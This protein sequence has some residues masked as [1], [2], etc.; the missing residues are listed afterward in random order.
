MADITTFEKLEEYLINSEPAKRQET[1]VILAASKDRISS[2]FKDVGKFVTYDDGKKPEAFR[3]NGEKLSQEETVDLMS[4]R[5]TFKDLAAL[6]ASITPNGGDFS[7]TNDDPGR[8]GLKITKAEY[9]EVFKKDGHVEKNDT[10]Y[11][12]FDKN[13]K[14][15][16]VKDGKLDLTKLDV[17]KAEPTKPSTEAGAKPSAPTATRANQPAADE[18]APDPNNGGR[19]ETDAGRGDGK[20]KPGFFEQWG[21]PLLAVGGALLGGLLGGGIFEI[22]IAALVAMVAF[23]AFNLGET[24]DNALAPKTTPGGTN[25]GSNA[26]GQSQQREQAP[27]AGP[28]TPLEIGRDALQADFSLDQNGGAVDST[29]G[30]TQYHGEVRGNGNKRYLQITRVSAVDENGDFLKD[31]NG[32]RTMQN[33]SDALASIQ[34][35]IGKDGRVDLTNP[36]IKTSLEKINIEGQKT[37]RTTRDKEFRLKEAQELANLK[38]N[39]KIEILVAKDSGNTDRFLAKITVESEEKGIRVK[40]AYDA[41]VNM[42]T[43][44]LAEN[45]EPKKKFSGSGDLTITGGQKIDPKTG[46]VIGDLDMKPVTIRDLPISESGRILIVSDEMRQFNNTIAGIKAP[47]KVES[48]SS[49]TSDEIKAAASAGNFKVQGSDLRVTKDFANFGFPT[50]PIPLYLAAPAKLGNKKQNER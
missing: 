9:E 7:H 33:V 20:K 2:F 36:E 12:V 6:A 50:E 41:E 45:G 44:Y 15:L 24:I 46:E 26:T 31:T 19:G 17:A 10:R 8:G 1:Q 42:H 4:P 25:R 27:L 34:I 49:K 48:E 3:K 35:P 29:A 22:L 39:P 23:K 30:K 32:K 13:G 16:P 5:Q 37:L 11:F 40:R 47:V 38:D 43:A 28:P 18:T 21:M 14:E